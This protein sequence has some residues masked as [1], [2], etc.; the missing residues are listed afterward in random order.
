[1][2]LNTDQLSRRVAALFRP[3]PKLSLTLGDESSF[4]RFRSLEPSLISCV[5]EHTGTEKPQIRYLVVHAENVPAGVLSLVVQANARRP[6][7]A[8]LFAR[9]DLV[10]VREC[11]RD[12]GLGKLLVLSSIVHAVDVYA[13]RLYSISCLAAHGA[14]AKI[15]ERVGFTRTQRVNRNFI[16]EELRLDPGNIAE[17]TERFVV[18]ARAA[19][20]AANFRVHQRLKTS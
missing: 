9:I 14:I 18:E 2:A 4:R 16:H 13:D 19:A 5:D 8:C 7:G 11:Y 17:L 1:M 15:L 10:I 3:Y 12:L 20:Q 6:T